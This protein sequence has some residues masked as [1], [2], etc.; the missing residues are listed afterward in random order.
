MGKYR[1]ILFSSITTVILIWFLLPLVIDYYILPIKDVCDFNTS[2]NGI[3][4]LFSGLAFAIMIIAIVIQRED[5]KNQMLI[6]QDQ[7]NVAVE[8]NKINE[9]YSLFDK[10][11]ILLEKNNKHILD[12]LNYSKITDF[13]NYLTRKPSSNDY[14]KFDSDIRCFFYNFIRIRHG[15]Y[16]YLDKHLCVILEKTYGREIMFFVTA[17]ISD[18]SI[19]KSELLSNDLRETI[20]DYLKD[21][22]Y[23]DKRMD[24]KDS[25]YEKLLNK[26]SNYDKI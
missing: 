8:A 25:S 7:I 22:D 16:D 24:I 14:Q 2:Y 1:F 11:L 5:F 13:V 15:F 12:Y 19:W 9:K 10:A 18:S 23:W 21:A 17:I 3:G 26:I 6:Q 4:A 20:I